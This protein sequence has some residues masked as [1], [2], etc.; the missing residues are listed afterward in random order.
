MCSVI[1]SLF[2]PTDADPLLTF[3]CS[4]FGGFWFR[5]VLDYL[6][7][8]LRPYGIHS[9]VEPMIRDGNGSSATPETTTN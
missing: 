2:S 3:V 1:F 9:V 5:Y 7:Y 6:L 4:F 8:H